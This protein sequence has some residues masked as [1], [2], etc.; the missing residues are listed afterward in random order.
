[1]FATTTT[2][3]SLTAPFSQVPIDDMVANGNVS[4]RLDHAVASV[5]ATYATMA[6][7]ATSVS[8]VVV[9]N[10]VP[11]LVFKSVVMPVRA[12]AAHTHRCAP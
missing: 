7:N 4:I 10:D 12:S 5:D 8:A 6:P 11:G 2:T 3:T 1:M 9:D